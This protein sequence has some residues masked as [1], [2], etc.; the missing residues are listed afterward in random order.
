MSPYVSINGSNAQKCVRITIFD[1][2]SNIISRDSCDESEEGTSVASKIQRASTYSKKHPGFYDVRFPA[3]AGSLFVFSRGYREL[4]FIAAGP[5]RIRLDIRRSDFPSFR[6]LG[7][8]TIQ[9]GDSL[10][11]SG[12]R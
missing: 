5:T 8:P 4:R 7:I 6:R 3:I 12:L 9:S 1:A 2:Y 11:G 10:R